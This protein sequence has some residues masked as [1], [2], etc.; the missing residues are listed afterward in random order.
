[1]DLSGAVKGYWGGRPTGAPAADIAWRY[2]ID[3]PAL[4][5]VCPEVEVLAYAADVER[6]RL[7]LETYRG[8]LGDASLSM[9]VRPAIPDAD[10]PGNLA[11]KVA[12][13]RELGLERVDFYHYG[14]VRLESL[15]W[16]RAALDA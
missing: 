13:A 6:V 7:D 15:D 11:A 9:A 4:A 5:R 12:L 16:I 2:G 1:M 3:L 10:G 14:F 8:I